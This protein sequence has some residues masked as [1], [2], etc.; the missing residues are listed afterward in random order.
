[1]RKLV[2]DV[3]NTT[4]QLTDKYRDFSPYNPNNKLVSVGWAWLIDGIIGPTMYAFMYHKELVQPQHIRIAELKRNIAEAEVIIAHNAKY[5]M[6]WLEES[7]FDLSH[8][9][10]EDTM[11][12]EYVMARGRG[13]ISLR[14]GDTCKRYNVTNKGELF[15][16]YPDLQISEMPILEV[17]DY[18]RTDVQACAELYLAQIERLKKDGYQS[19]AKTIDMMNEFC[20]VL[21]DME[22]AGVK[23]DE[24]ALLK[25]EADYVDEAEHLKFWLNAKVKEVMGDTPVNLDSPAQLSEVIYSRSLKA[26][27]EEQWCRVFN[28][29]RDDRGKPLRRPRMGTGEYVANVKEMTDVVLKTVA[30]ACAGCEGRGW[31]QKIRKDG[32]PFKNTTKCKPCSGSGVIYVELNQPAGFR[33][34]P[35]NIAWTTVS[36]FS[37]SQ[38]FLD[39]LA[40]EATGDA[41]DF[42]EKLQRLSSISSYLSNFVGG[43]KTF[44][45]YDNIL[46]PNFNQCIT[47][48]GRLSC[49]KPNL[50]NQPREQTF[51][52]RKVF[53]SR[54]Q[55]GK[56]TETDFRQLEFRAAIHLARC[57]K[58]KED[59]LNDI[60]VHNQTARII[61]EAGQPIGRQEAK[62]RTFKPLYGGTTG[63]EAERKYY[64]AFLKEIYTGVYA[65]HKE[66]QETAIAKHIITL[67][68]GRQYIF[69]D[70]QRAWHG[71][72][73]RATQIC[74]Y[75]VQGFATAD[76]VPIAIIALRKVFKSK[77][78]RSIIIL[79]VH[80]SVMVDTHPEEEAIVIEL[81]NNI[82]RYAEEELSQRYGI[83]TFVPL[84]TETKIGYNGMEL[85]KVA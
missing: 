18:G 33:F 29:G 10:V 9:A 30:K 43:I 45:Q 53:I 36:G 11:I 71:G 37:T 3:E 63:T 32:T 61:T 4:T 1:M 17:E 84:D 51:P 55:G 2:L 26:G 34:K 52:I 75:P 50:Q 78:L 5:D 60:D 7:G 31:I 48:T 22:R 46:H 77:G 81:M 38:T 28:I 74:N 40:S 19:L 69:P 56:I 59:I 79:S 25:V 64:Q 12:R 16:K 20:R 73:T 83:T 15:D 72:A 82:G 85:K 8:L 23:I 70:V 39:E 47:A 35:K 65:W 58:G 24:E 80:D 6:Q 21:V 41:K 54:F 14:L 67:P 76:I 42:V 66:L 49:T 13:D 57:E 27:K 68:T 44:K 62:S